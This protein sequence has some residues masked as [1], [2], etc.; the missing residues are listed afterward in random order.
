MAQAKRQKLGK[1]VN[2]QL[3]RG[4]AAILVAIF[5]ANVF[6]TQE[7]YG[8]IFSEVL[9]FAYARVEFFFVLSGFI[10]FYIH[11]RHIGVAGKFKNFLIKRFTR[12]YPIYWA[13]CIPFF[14]ALWWRQD[15]ADPVTWHDIWTSLLLFPT[16]HYPLLVPA[17]TLRIEMLFYLFF[18]LLLLSKRLGYGLFAL[19]IGGSLYAALTGP[20]SFPMNYLFSSYNVLFVVGM[21]SAYYVKRHFVP[22]PGV[23]TAIGFVS[24]VVIGLLDTFVFYGAGQDYRIL[25]LG[26]SVFFIV[27]GLCGLEQC[28]IRSPKSLEFIGNASYSIFLVHG[29]T[30]AILGVLLQKFGLIEVLSPGAFFFLMTSVGIIAGGVFYV[31]MEKRI[32]NLVRV[33]LERG[34]EKQAKGEAVGAL[35]TADGQ[36]VLG[37]GAPMLR[38]PRPSTS[39]G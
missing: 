25:A 15:P 29:P 19:W 30:M 22:M 34:K 32:V 31:T 26:V 20:I 16:D 9:N 17:W 21:A 36:H 2:F 28:G 35:A 3:G 1:V 18:A 14:A 7:Y 24:F 5:H 13:V 37:G 11:D 6:Y 4:I 12:I 33:L 10:M 8:Q 38:S 23:L 27:V 39:S